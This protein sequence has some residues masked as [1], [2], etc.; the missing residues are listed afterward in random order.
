MRSTNCASGMSRPRAER[1]GRTARGLRAPVL[2]VAT[3]ALVGLLAL[4]VPGAAQSV[5][6]DAPVLTR[7]VQ[8]VLARLQEGW[9]QW[10]TA[11]YGADSERALSVVDDLLS[12]A[13]Q[14]GMQH[15]PDLASGAML[16]AVEAA[17]EGD[18]AR[19]DLALTAAERLDPGRPETAFAAAEVAR[20]TGDP[21]GR[22]E[23]QVRGYARLFNHELLRVPVVINLG[24]WLVVSLL[25]AGV[26]F[27]CLLVLTDGRA[28]VNDLGRALAG[29][30]PRAPGPLIQVLIVMVLL[31]PLLL[32]R[33]PIWLVIYWSLLLWRKAAPSARTVVALLWLLLGL[34]PWLADRGREL[35]NLRTSPPVQAMKSVIDGRLYGD[36]FLDLRTLTTVLPGS[37]PV[38]QFLGDF[39]VRFGQWDIARRRYEQVLEQEPENVASMIDLGAYYLNQGDHGNAVAMF[40]KAAEIDPQSA[41][42]QFD[43][44]LAYAE[45]YLYDE[46]REAL[47]EARKIDDR[48][49][50]EWMRRPVRQRIVTVEGGFAREPE[51]E[52]ALARAWAPPTQDAPWLRTVLNLR[53]LLALIGIAG[54]GLALI[55]ALA[56]LTRTGDPTHALRARTVRPLVSPFLEALVPG[57]GAACQRRGIAAFFATLVPAGLLVALVA[58][59]GFG[60]GYPVPWRYDPGGWFLLWLAAAAIILVV[61]LRAGRALLRRS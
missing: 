51:I 17:R 14:V 33:G 31:W 58:T 13:D 42:A 38:E 34:T 8:E 16:Q 47:D 45:S 46:Q 21:V 9:L 29:R 52:A 50:T 26:L 59:S 5:S 30:L 55:P 28:V 53:S 27:L 44:S 3:A 25:T 6:S 10:T 22:I 61:A 40:Q 57:F 2:V 15:L 18:A 49:V 48:K 1:G 54:L 7:S 36:L 37:A 41:A 39:H 12:S 19:A 4:A 23:A 24:L 43:L 32:P 60:F 35:L 56:R 20:A 11:L